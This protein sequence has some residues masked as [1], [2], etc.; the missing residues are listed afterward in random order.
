MK[1]GISKVFIDTAPFIYLIEGSKDYSSYIQKIF[2][3]CMSN[4]I[5][6][7]TSII[8]YFEFCVKPYQLDKV[9]L[10]NSLK[11]LFSEL[12]IR[13]ILAD[14]NVAD[15]AS[16]LR[17]KYG[18]LKPMDALQLASA[19]SANCQLFVTNDR[20]LKKVSEIEVTLVSEW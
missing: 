16:K 19:I 9:E 20:Q 4:D 11:E 6:L 3:D 17:A 8:T 1:T 14:L 5:I 2:E 12:G 15:L 7:Y 18:F 10:I 13:I